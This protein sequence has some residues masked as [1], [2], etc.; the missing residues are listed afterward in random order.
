MN[1]NIFDNLTNPPESVYTVGEELIQN[2]GTADTQRIIYKVLKKMDE[3]DEKSY[4]R[5]RL[6]KRISIIAAATLISVFIFSLPVVAEN[7]YAVY[8]NLAG[9]T[10]ATEFENAK[11]MNIKV[12]DPNLNID[13][14]KVGGDEG[15]A[16]LIEITLSKKN[17]GRFVD[18]TFSMVKEA[19]LCYEINGEKMGYVSECQMS[20][21]Y[22]TGQSEI[23]DC[24][25]GESYYSIEDNGRVMK[26]LLFIR[27]NRFNEEYNVLYDRN[28]N[29]ARIKIESY[30]FYTA[31][32]DRVIESSYSMNQEIHEEWNQISGRI[33]Q[34]RYPFFY[35]IMTNSFYYTDIIYTGERWELVEG[36]SKKNNLPFEIEFTLDSSSESKRADIEDN[37]L[38]KLFGEYES[39]GE[40]LISPYGMYIYAKNNDPDIVEGNIHERVIEETSYVK[41]KGGDI[42]YLCGSKA[43]GN[44]SCRDTL[45]SLSYSKNHYYNSYSNDKTVY[46]IDINNIDEVFINGVKVYQNH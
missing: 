20:I 1:R 21:R 5:K 11:D 17:G 18:N 37:I 35:D 41:M 8:G 44:S 14:V 6:A 3:E 46:V 15:G 12:S 9:Y 27:H 4:K 36:R 32:V 43:N 16:N 30:R 45:I 24:M 2:N 13:S 39:N 23:Y 29:G 10:Y 40:M 33:D 19:P 7:L 22:D 31:S 42:Y 34:E 26:I 28:L 25:K 38:K